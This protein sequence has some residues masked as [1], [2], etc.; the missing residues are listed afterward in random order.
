[1]TYDVIIAAGGVSLRVGYDKLSE[2]IGEKTV[3]QRAVNAFLGQ[4]NLGRIIVVGK[5]VDGE[6][7]LCVEGGKTRHESVENGLRFVTAETVLIH[8]AARPFVT[9]DLIEK[10]A[11]DAEQYGSAIPC[12]PFFDSLRVVEDGCLVSSVDRE[13]TF[14]VQTPQGFSTAAIRKAFSLASPDENYTDESELYAKFIAPCHV[15]AG[16]PNN[17]KITVES[18]FYGLN[19][20]IG[21]GFDVHRYTPGKPLKLCGVTIPYEYGLLAHSDGDAPLH[22]LMDALLT[23]AGERDIGVLFPDTDPQYKDIDSA[24][25]LRTVLHILHRKNLEILSVNLTVIAQSPRLSPYI[26]EMRKNL[27]NLLSLSPDRISLSAT[28]TENL[29]LIGENKALAA[30][31]SVL[32]V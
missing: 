17:K 7:V 9:R 29:G 15:V 13:K 12:V 25:L 32:L 27:A 2:K 26:E 8:D 4:K 23:A 11:E 3:L 10:I 22:A 19:A 28:T 24:V 16:D 21:S 31:A 5:T 30:M 18:D 6:N 14:A 20:R 1:M